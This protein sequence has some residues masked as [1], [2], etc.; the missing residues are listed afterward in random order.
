MLLR[1]LIVS[2]S[3]RLSAGLAALSR[4]TT[5]WW[6]SCQT[7]LYSRFQRQRT[8]KCSV[9]AKGRQARISS[10][11]SSNEPSVDCDSLKFGLK[12]HQAGRTL[13]QVDASSAMPNWDLGRGDDRLPRRKPGSKDDQVPGLSVG[14]RAHWRLARSS[15]R[16]TRRRVEL[17]KHALPA[18]SP[19]I[20]RRPLSDVRRP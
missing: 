16:P 3:R 2:M 1:S 11:S 18:A 10:L 20:A 15:R 9:A 12:H 8:S 5:S 19:L 17:Q 4:G 14:G 6:I 7:L 13:R